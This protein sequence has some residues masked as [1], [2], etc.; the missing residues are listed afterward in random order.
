[1]TFV[2]LIK[3]ITTLWSRSLTSFRGQSRDVRCNHPFSSTNHHHLC[4]KP[5]PGT[6]RLA[7]RVVALGS[8]EL[9]P[10]TPFIYSLLLQKPLSLSCTSTSASQLTVHDTNLKPSVACRLPR[11]CLRTPS[12]LPLLPSPCHPSTPTRSHPSSHPLRT[13]LLRSPIEAATPA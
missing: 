13:L 8:S 10:S 2:F 7:L 3:L 11:G 5:M 1:L 4:Q 12:T 9:G 6:A